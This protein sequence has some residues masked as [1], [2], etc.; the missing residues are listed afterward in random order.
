MLDDVRLRVADDPEG[1]FGRLTDGA[2]RQVRSAYP[3][4]GPSPCLHGADKRLCFQASRPRTCS[5][6]PAPRTGLETRLPHAP[7]YRR[8]MCT[9]FDVRQQAGPAHA[10]KAATSLPMIA[11]RKSRDASRLWESFG[12]V[13]SLVT[14]HGA[15]EVL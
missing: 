1:V 15:A 6:A 4:T 2:Q 14:R 13:W 3:G 7:F 11:A 8:T 9:A 10:R 12:V 5:P